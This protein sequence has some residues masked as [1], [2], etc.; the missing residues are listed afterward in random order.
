MMRT[1]IPI[2]ARFDL[3][4]FA[5]PPK[6][7]SQGI[8]STACR[9]FGPARR[10]AIGRSGPERVDVPGG[11]AGDLDDALG[12]GVEVRA[13]HRRPV[14]RVLD[15]LPESQV[16]EERASCVEDDRVEHR[17]RWRKKRWRAFAGR[18]AVRAVAPGQLSPRAE[19]RR[20]AHEIVRQVVELSTVD[21]RDRFG[22]GTSSVITIRAARRGRLPP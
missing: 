7:E 4:M 21:E 11:V 15:R 14:E 1:A 20:S 16:P 13:C 9:R 18:R 12:G 3:R 8:S 6:P 17:L 19:Q 2:L 10:R 22:V 5:A